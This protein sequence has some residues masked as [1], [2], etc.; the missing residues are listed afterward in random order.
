M[1]EAQ[2]K[3]PEVQ[4]GE[5][6]SETYAQEY[7]ANVTRSG[8]ETVYN[9]VNLNANESFIMDHKSKFYDFLA[10]AIQELIDTGQIKF[11]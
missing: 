4:L 7:V 5:V 2:E 8:P 6:G 11:A 10:E 1:K 3:F 9:I